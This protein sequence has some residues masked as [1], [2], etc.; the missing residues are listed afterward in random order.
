MDSKPT[1]HLFEEE[2]KE[3][4]IKDSVCYSISGVHLKDLEKINKI[5]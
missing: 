5:K 4:I 3:E 1:R 2:T